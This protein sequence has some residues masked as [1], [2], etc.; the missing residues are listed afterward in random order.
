[1]SIFAD[2][3]PCEQVRQIC[4]LF[5]ALSAAAVFLAVILNFAL[6]EPGNVRRQ[7]RS[8]V[9]TG[10][11]T[12]FFFVVYLL[13]NR[14]LGEIPV[15]ALPICL[16]LAFLGTTAVVL[17]AVVNLLGRV[18]LG[19]NWANQVTLREDQTL[20]TH[21]IYGVV[22]HPLYASLIWMFCGAAVAYRN[23]AA[24]AATLLIFVP[25]MIVRAS[26]EE[27]LLVEQFPEYQAYR[28]RVGMFWPKLG[29]RR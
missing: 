24:L 17:G 27:T 9:A 26:Q 2:L 21:G 25:A 23:V 10:S 8:V 4:S 16:T 5:I 18:R 6:A 28:R 11:M 14:R 7:R 15:S 20:V 19:R 1:M 13:I 22:R 3:S 29:R 12:G